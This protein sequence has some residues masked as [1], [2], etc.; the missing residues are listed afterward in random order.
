MLALIKRISIHYLFLAFGAVATAADYYV[1]DGSTVGD[2]YTTAVGSAANDG[3]TPATPKASLQNLINAYTLGPGDNIYVDAGSYVEVVDVSGI[4]GTAANYISFIGADSSSTIFIPPTAGNDKM[5]HL[6][7][8]HYTLW[9]QFKIDGT[10][11][12]DDYAFEIFNDCSYN[13]VEYFQI[14]DCYYGMDMRRSISG[15]PP[16]YNHFRNSTVTADWVGVR[17]KSDGF[18]DWLASSISGPH[19]NEVYDNKIF[20]V[21]PTGTGYSAIESQ[22]ARNNLFYR[23]HALA[24]CMAL[25]EGTVHSAHGTTGNTFIN[26][27]LS[28]MN[29]GQ[30]SYDTDDSSSVIFIHNS[31]YSVDVCWKFDGVQGDNIDGC[32]LRNNIFESL[33]SV[34][35]QLDVAGAQFK[36]ISNN[37]YYSASN[38]NVANVNGVM[39]DLAAWQ[40]YDP[41]VGTGNA[42]NSLFGDPNYIDPS[43][44]L[45][46]LACFSPAINAVVSQVSNVVV[47]IYNTPR[48]VGLIEDIGA[49][50]LPNV[51]AGD[52]TPDESIICSG[53]SQNLLSEGLDGNDYVGAIVTWE[54]AQDGFTWGSTDGTFTRLTDST[55]TVT[56]SNSLAVP[57]TMYY[58]LHVA[59]F[60]AD[61]S[62]TVMII[63]NPIA[64]AGDVIVGGNVCLPNTITIE[65]NNEFGD[66]IYWETRSPGGSW[67][68]VSGETSN[69]ITVA[70][71]ADANYRA[72]IKYSNQVCEADT[73]NEAIV[74]VV[75]QGADAGEVIPD[76]SICIGSSQIISMVNE[77]G[78][79]IYWE[80]S[81][82]GM[83]S[84]SVITGETG[85]GIMV[86]PNQSMDYRGIIKF[87]NEICSG[88]TTNE[89]TI[90]VHPTPISGQINGGT[91]C[92]G[93]DLLIQLTG[94]QGDSIYWE[95]SAAGLNSWSV[96]VGETADNILVS[97]ATATDYRAF[98][99]YAGGLCSIEITNTATVTVSSTVTPGSFVNAPI[100]Y[101]T[102][103]SDVL[104]ISAGTGTTTWEESSDRITFG[105][106][107]GT[108]VTSTSATVN[109]TASGN[110][111]DTTWIRVHYEASCVSE[112]SDTAMIIVHPAPVAGQITGATICLG[113]EQLVQLTGHHGDSIYWEESLSG[114]EN[115]SLI[116]GESV[117]NILV[118]PVKPTDYR[119]F[120][121]YEGG[122]CISDVTNTATVQVDSVNPSVSI[123][124]SDVCE[125][126][127]QLEASITSTN[128]A[129]QSP[130]FQWQINGNN[131]G[132]GEEVLNTTALNGD[133]VNLIM[134]SSEACSMGPVT[135]DDATV[136]AEKCEC[137]I[138]IPTAISPNEDGLND[139]WQIAGLSCWDFWKVSVYNRYGSLVWE[140]L[141]KGSND[142][143]YV[144][145]NGE[146]NGKSMPVAVY[147]Y[148]IEVS[149][150]EQNETYS[151]QL[152]IM[153]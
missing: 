114:S 92:P 53:D 35:I 2:V 122:L 69:S 36:E 32:V 62:D 134:N 118:S 81:I 115:W 49:H 149:I 63:T 140:Q 82:T 16:R 73:T 20:L 7:D 50:E 120:V 131:V 100:A 88:D 130:T 135:S 43:Q 8:V 9:S 141:S 113:N 144:P 93:D 151:G 80:Q 24:N 17:V 58:R 52:V 15:N 37:L 99:K 59:C 104:N 70:P 21:N 3:L 97:P 91:I 123:F 57:D 51:Y 79:S 109:Y 142:K 137:S 19:D 87:A 89:I 119:A 147:Y 96:L 4:S 23:N 74:T 108:N 77:A 146:R 85:P 13:I 68:V 133:I 25:V 48:P 31:F 94:Y 116:V 39:Y 76:D 83:N 30:Y 27:Y 128:D 75:N 145:W 56:R 90:V 126:D 55:G 38:T 54:Q 44:A 102:G 61:T 152:T 138:W 106:F 78:D 45:L 22:A 111:H 148:V 10:A 125:E 71:L 40:A 86:S 112:Y 46:D 28:N 26:N 110:Q 139:S 64:Q 41:D 66:S 117:D 136:F 98:V 67:T 1:N 72:I 105:P 5:F 127:G 103:G 12:G 18:G 121:K 34:P 129:G 6:E 47:D 150:E 11:P 107:A 124:I 14:N 60:H 143:I 132:Q 101:C 153:R 95:Q 33:N 84:W 65:M 42:A 29:L